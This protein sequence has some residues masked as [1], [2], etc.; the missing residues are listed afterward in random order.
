[1]DVTIDRRI[2]RPV[3]I[4]AIDLRSPEGL[5]QPFTLLT[6]R[7]GEA[8]DPVVTA[9]HIHLPIEL[10]A[11]ASMIAGAFTAHMNDYLA[12]KLSAPAAPPEHH[13]TDFGVET[14]TP[15]PAEAVPPADD[16]GRYVRLVAPAS[17]PLAFGG[18]GEATDHD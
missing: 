14:G 6:I 16:R 7:Q 18:Q 3:R 11:V 13:A 8:T 15:V 10:S 17:G 1:M 9:V 5:H 12:G 4:T 2:E